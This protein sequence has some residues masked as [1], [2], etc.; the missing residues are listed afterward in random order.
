MEKKTNFEHIFLKYIYY[1][2]EKGFSLRNFWKFGSFYDR[3]GKHTF[4]SVYSLS[5]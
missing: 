2:P 4:F 1:V 5:Q 3:F